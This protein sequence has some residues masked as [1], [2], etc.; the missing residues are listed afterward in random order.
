[1]T[2]KKDSQKQCYTFSSF[3]GSSSEWESVFVL[4]FPLTN[5][6]RVW[7]KFKNSGMWWWSCDRVGSLLEF[8]AKPIKVVGSRVLVL[9]QPSPTR[10][11]IRNAEKADTAAQVR[12]KKGSRSAWRS[13]VAKKRMVQILVSYW[14]VAC[15]RRV[16]WKRSRIDYGRL[17]YECECGLRYSHEFA[18]QSS[19]RKRRTVKYL[20]LPARAEFVPSSSCFSCQLYLIIRQDIIAD[21]IN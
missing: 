4:A 3:L 11:L 18:R 2:V 1:M 7:L 16:K 15:V 5:V 21:N 6:V 10:I 8:V 20:G 13:S 9:A 12:L 19:G 14:L 17:G